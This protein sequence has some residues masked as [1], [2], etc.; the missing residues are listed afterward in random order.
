MFPMFVDPIAPVL[1]AG[2][3]VEGLH[4]LASL[5]V[6]VVAGA[7][8]VVALVRRDRS[9]PRAEPGSTPLRKAA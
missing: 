9:E 7:G 3:V 8:V 2:L 4:V 6:V 5:A 1:A